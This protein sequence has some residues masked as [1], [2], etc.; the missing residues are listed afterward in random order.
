MHN[1]II[2]KRLFNY[3]K[4]DPKQLT[5]IA[6]GAANN[7][8]Q[9]LPTFM[10][11]YNMD[12]RILIFDP[13]LEQI[14][15]YFTDNQLPYQLCQVNGLKI[16]RYGN[17]EFIC[18]NDIISNT[19]IMFFKE[20]SDIIMAYS[21]L[22]L[23]YSYAGYNLFE[24]QQQLYDV[25]YKDDLNTRQLYLDHILLDFTYGKCLGCFPDLLDKNNHPDIILH[26]GIHKI[27]NICCYH[28]DNN[29]EK[30]IDVII[31][32]DIN[33]SKQIKIYLM[34]IMYKLNNEIYRKFRYYKETT[35]LAKQYNEIIMYLKD[36]YKNMTI[37]LNIDFNV[38]EFLMVIHNG[39]KYKCFDDINLN[40]NQKIKSLEIV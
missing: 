15:K 3:I 34:N 4:N 13:N 38:E 7:A 23:G 5:Y 24:I 8:E 33:M 40:I 19:D 22:L 17:Y 6:I 35:D 20:L 28:L 18:I 12:T 11:N 9:Q 27:V 29:I 25:F 10:L 14:L 21:G 39:D 16:Y 37:L 31:N 2:K 26:D 32:T 30:I 1:I 36:I